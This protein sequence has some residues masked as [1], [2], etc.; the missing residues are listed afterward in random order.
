MKGEPA[1]SLGRSVAHV[2]SKMDGSPRPMSVRVSP[3]VLPR[4]IGMPDD[5]GGAS[6]SN[7]SRGSDRPS[8]TGPR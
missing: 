1:S 4:I 3:R 6:G 2:N 5:W 8:L 7:G